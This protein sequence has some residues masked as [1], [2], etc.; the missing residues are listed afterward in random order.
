MDRAA[1]NDNGAAPCGKFGAPCRS[2]CG[3]PCCRFGSPGDDTVEV[4]EP[5]EDVFVF[6][7]ETRWLWVVEGDSE[8]VDRWVR[9]DAKFSGMWQSVGGVVRW[10][11]TPVG[12]L[13]SARS[14]C[15]RG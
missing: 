9:V 7:G 5:V 14:F 4:V 12:G 2:K 10:W 3:A 6:W 11:L 1:G 8:D 13:R 15:P